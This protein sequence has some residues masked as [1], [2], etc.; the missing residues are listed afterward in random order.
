M[1][2]VVWTLVFWILELCIFGFRIV[3]FWDLELL[4]SQIWD[5]WVSHCFLILDLGILD[6]AHDKKTLQSNI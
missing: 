3:Y 6:F 1:Q 5:V 4:D 2:Y